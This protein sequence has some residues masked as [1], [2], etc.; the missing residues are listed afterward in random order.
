[1][2]VFAAPRPGLS[3]ADDTTL[4]CRCEE[5]TKAEI[6]AVMA[7]GAPAIG[8]AIS[9]L[10]VEGRTRHDLS[11]FGARRWTGGPGAGIAKIAGRGA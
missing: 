1:M 11:M 4:I 2:T 10:I 3:L 8:E 5:V 6:A 9:D 7:D